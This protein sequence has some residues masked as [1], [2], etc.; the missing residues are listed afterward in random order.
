[1]PR[2]STGIA[3]SLE[4]LTIS[5]PRIAEITPA[6]ITSAIARDRCAGGATSAVAFDF[7]G[8]YLAVGGA[9]EQPA[10]RV[11]PEQPVEQPVELPEQT[12]RK[13]H[14]TLCHPFT[15]LPV[16]CLTCSCPHPPLQTRACTA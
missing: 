10:E 11:L 12:D 15:C 13:M 7:S 9:G 16:L 2:N 4:C 14:A 3:H 8:L 5:G 1:M 6:A